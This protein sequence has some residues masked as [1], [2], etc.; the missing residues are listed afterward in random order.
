[1]GSEAPPGCDLQT[2]FPFDYAKYL[3]GDKRIGSLPESARGAPVAIIGAGGSGLAAAYEL[4]RIGCRPIIYEAEISPDGPGGRRLGGRMYSLRLDPAD[5]AVVELGCSRFPDSARLLRQYAAEFGLDWAPFRDPYASD[6][7]PT[8]VLEIDDVRYEASEIADLYSQHEDFAY[9][10]QSWRAAL[11]RLGLDELRHAV[12]VRD[13][14]QVRSRW[15]ALVAEYEQWTFYRFLRD[16][17]GCGLTHE[18]SQVLGAAG[19]G[20]LVADSFFHASVIEVLRTLLV[21]EGSTMYFAPNGIGALAE[22]FWHHRAQTP[23][24]NSASLAEINDGALRPAVTSIEVEHDGGHGVV[25]HDAEG[26]TAHYAAAIFTPQ[27]QLLET[28]VDVRVRNSQAS[29]FGPRIRRAIRRI[30]YW[31]VTKT[32]L[33]VDRPFWKGTSLDGVTLTDR[34]PRACYTMEYPPSP[35]GRS[36]LIDLSFAWGPDAMR[37]AASDTAER[38]RVLVRELSRIHP[39]LADELAEAAGAEAVSISWENRPN[40]RG[41]CR[42]SR[43]GEYAY[44]RDL[45]C[46]FLKD[47]HGTAAVPGEPPNALFLAGDDTIWSSAWLDRALASGINAAW[48]VLRHLGGRHEPDNPGPGDLWGHPHYTPGA[49]SASTQRFAH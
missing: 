3:A 25:V 4:M 32:A 40:F 22:G 34:L 43:P 1:M 17:A 18:Q 29:P 42:V 49:L 39:E 14:A 7:T 30:T 21:T 20:P 16:P 31:Q 24:G 28:N 12:A 45:F 27:L 13:L 36:A 5:S 44:Q 48:G 9:A 15:D 2:D 11:Q 37:I 35:G 10:H 23:A 38:V 26:G 47:F 46:H 41:L 8:T 19:T 6:A 33:V